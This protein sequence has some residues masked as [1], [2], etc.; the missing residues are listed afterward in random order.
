LYTNC[1]T[2]NGPN[3][4]YTNTAQRLLEACKTAS[5]NEYQEQFQQIENQLLNVASSYQQQMRD[6]LSQD[7]NSNQSGTGGPIGRSSS[8]SVDDPLTDSESRP[9]NPSQQVFAQNHQVISISNKSIKSSSSSSSS[10]QQPS[11]RLN[12]ANLHALNSKASGSKKSS[13]DNLTLRMKNSPKSSSDAEVFVDVESVD[14]RGG[15]TAAAIILNRGREFVEERIEE[16]TEEEEEEGEFEEMHNK[17]AMNE[18]EVYFEYTE[19]IDED[20]QNNYEYNAEY[21]DDDEQQY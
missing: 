17:E 8:I 3:N 20:N 7:N 18:E 5:E 4:S 12:F 10:N 14:E 9:H 21:Q 1:L 2:Y 6:E 19:Q 11:V 16:E 13:K 15:G